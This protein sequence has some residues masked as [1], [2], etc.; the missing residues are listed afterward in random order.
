MAL[1]NAIEGARHTG[2]QITWTHDDGTAQNLTGATMSGIIR[3]VPT[4]V[5]TAI[6]GTLALVTA[7]SGIFTWA[8][9]AADIATAGEYVVQFKA[10]FGSTFALSHWI[11]WLI[12]AGPASASTKTR[13]TMLALIDRVRDLLGPCSTGVTDIQIQDRLD[14]HR[15]KLQ[16]QRLD[17]LPSVQASPS[18]QVRYYEYTAPFENWERGYSIQLAGNSI[19]GASSG[20]AWQVITPSVANDIEGRWTFADYY[21][22]AVFI[23]GYSYDVFASAADC[24]ELLAA[25]ELRAITFS[26]GGQTF[27]RGQIRQNYLDF[28]KTMRAQARVVSANMMRGDTMA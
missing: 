22:A 27:N 24:L 26:A 18:G 2:Q 7:A 23:T 13:P 12:E 28:A 16:L 19:S 17:A 14:R 4:G 11:N 1:E 15:I 25:G 10:D 9:S 20:E 21:Y 8:Y 6:T 5:E 3:D